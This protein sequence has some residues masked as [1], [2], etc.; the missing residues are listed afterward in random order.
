MQTASHIYSL[1]RELEDRIIGAKFI[2]TEFFKKERE[3]YL[4]FKTD[5]GVLALG[6]VYHPAGFGTF[7]I[8]R[9]KVKV[10]TNEKPWPF[11][12]EAFESKVSLVEQIGF[13]RI[14]KIC[15]EGSKQSFCIFVE[16][17][18]PNG[19]LWLTGKDEFIK[20][21][22][23]KRTYNKDTAYLPPPPFDRLNPYEIELR[24]L[25]EMFRKSDQYAENVM[26]KNIAGLDKYLI[27]E[28]LERSALD[29]HI[30]ADE[31]DDNSIGEI[32]SQIKAMNGLFGDYSRGYFYGI[33]D[34]NFVYPFKLRTL[35]N[36]F[37]K[38]KSLSFAVYEAVRTK[39]TA[40]SE[41]NVRQST[42][43]A[44]NRFIK[45][46][47][48][49]VTKIGA[50]LE[51]AANFE[52]YKKYAE[53]LKIN[54]TSIKKGWEEA[55][56]VDVYDDA[57][58][59]ISIKLDPALNAAQNADAYFKKYRKG[60]EGLSLLERRLEIAQGELESA[61]EM[62][63]EFENDYDGAV[64]KYEAEVASIR[65]GTADKR[66]APIRLPY[67][68]T[69]LTSGL[70]VY[71]GRD[72]SDNDTTTF[73]HAK[74][75]ELWFHASQCPG[76]HVVLKFPSKS[77]EP[78]R[79]EIEETAAIAAY[80]SKARNSKRVPVIYTIRKYVRKPRGAKAGLV[81]VEREKMV[82]VEPKKPE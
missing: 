63:T 67:K 20:A 8:P 80:H 33:G 37:S 64:Q 32:V 2:G 66:A 16:A 77:F 72:G 25:V 15:L 44:V 9:G 58:G 54:I 27:A 10:E 65:P 24:H 42:I 51:S 61:L 6:M 35:G 34:G 43:D 50:D 45:R 28:I 3:A 62:Q 38:C 53:L 75:Y 21:T 73:R 71:V 60:R 19:N 39:K 47:K 41:I 17:I 29:M 55:I 1:V 11:F 26:K 74:P 57:A 56:V 52:Q 46:L 13:D 23:R 82:M 30:A 12:Q 7:L 68:A 59:E 70:T 31:I 49:K 48:R 4:H 76:S 14:F 5:K 79:F 81:T 40:R 18:G 22:L 69:T 36:D 78:S